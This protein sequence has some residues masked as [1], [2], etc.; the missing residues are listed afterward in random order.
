MF[1]A[2]CHLD[3]EAFDADRDAVLL[4]AQSVGMSGLIIA[5][6]D[7]ERRAL[8]RS[9]AERAGIWATAGLHPWALLGKDDAWLER[10]LEALHGDLLAGGFCGLGELG[11]DFYRATEPAD[12]AFQQ[13]AFVGQLAIARE[14]DLPLVIHAVKCHN[15]LYEILRQEG[16]PKSGGMMHGYSGSARQIGNFLMLNLDISIGTPATYPDAHK[17]RDV[18]L[19]TPGDRLLVETDAPDRAPHP[20]RHLRNTPALLALVIAAVAKARGC[21]PDEIARQCERNTRR[22]F[23]LGDERLSVA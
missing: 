23:Q 8:A 6:Y 3:F 19:A 1:D 14:L 20:D 9:L 4:D 22:R 16:V 15:S 7:R 11:L 21:K 10:E 18:I 17:L 12:R 2:H 13:K 5:G